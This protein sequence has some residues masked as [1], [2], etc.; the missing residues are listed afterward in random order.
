MAI[1]LANSYN[2]NSVNNTLPYT[3][4]TPSFTPATNELIVVKGCGENQGVFIGTP[5]ATGGGISWTN[6]VQS[7]VSN[8]CYSV[9]WTGVVTSGGSSITVSTTTTNGGS[10]S[11]YSSMTVERWTGAQIAASPAT[12]SLFDGA[13]TTSTI[14]T[15][16]TNSVVT[17]L[18]GDW[19]AVSSSGETYS[20]GA[21]QD[22]LHDVSPSAYV[23]Y[24]AYQTAAVAGSQT[25]GLTA[26]AGRKDTILGLEIQDSSGGQPVSHLLTLTGIGM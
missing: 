15:T 3:L 7:T 13:S 14:T 4:T 12:S 22:G 24:Y 26:P 20:S 19:N 18:D 10:V 11:G 23:A 25:F 21:T 8:N 17:F 1:A 9:I 6:R 5:S 16:G 2:V